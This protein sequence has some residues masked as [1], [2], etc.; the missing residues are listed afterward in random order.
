MREDLPEELVELH[1]MQW[2]DFAHGMNGDMIKKLVWH[3]EQRGCRDTAAM[4]GFEY[5]KTKQGIVIKRYTGR[6]A[7]LWV[8][9]EYGGI[10]VVGIEDEAFR[11]CITL[12]SLRL[13]D[14]IKKI[15]KQAFEGCRN[16]SSVKIW[17]E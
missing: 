15:G 17:K 7:S 5:E 12:R 14:G 1:K 2:L 8:E 3:L 13:S 16:L 9:N 4:P 10:P 6:D 11:N